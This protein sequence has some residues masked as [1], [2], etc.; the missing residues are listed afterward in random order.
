MINLAV[1]LLKNSTKQWLT[2]KKGSKFI[3][4]A[5]LLI[6]ALF[7]LLQ[8]NVLSKPEEATAQLVGWVVLVILFVFILFGLLSNR[9]PSRMEDVMWI[10][11]LPMSMSRIVWTC[12]C[13]QLL[14]RS[15]FWLGSALIADTIRFLLGHTYEHLFFQAFMS[16][17]VISLLEVGLFAASSSRGKWGVSI[18]VGMVGAIGL[19]LTAFSFFVTQMEKSLFPSITAAM[20]L[21]AFYVGA[22][23]MGKFHLEGFL[24]VV[25]FIVLAIVVIQAAAKGLELKEK[26]TREA[27]F[28]SSFS[29]FSSLAAA[30]KGGD[31]A[32]Y[33]GGKAWTGV[34]SFVWFEWVLWRKH[35]SALV[36]QFI[37]GAGLA[38][39]MAIKWPS[40]LMIYFGII[41]ASALIGGFFS[42]L[43]RHAQ[44]GDLLLLPG[45]RLKKIVLLEIVDLIPPFAT[46]WLY[47]SISIAI[48]ANLSLKPIA[49]IGWLLVLIV[50]IACFR[51]SLFVDVFL[52]NLDISMGSYYKRLF[53]YSIAIAGIIFILLFL[54]STLIE[55]SIG[56]LVAAVMATV[57]LYGVI[58][59]YTYK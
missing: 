10:Y 47:Y 7:T 17:A 29:S 28:W 12:L 22:F 51:I 35:R 39:V 32:S 57:I 18:A 4:I 13:W 46:V 43:I 6:L 9:L 30:A 27:D 40:W 16:L 37:A 52:K 5:P 25:V 11:M 36:F 21:L 56:M 26:L 1:F 59:I 55:L 49:F 14:L 31:Q 3:I 41:L 2:N 38:I 53:I 50:A 48:G 24:F 23:M 33:W 44:S 34:F 54:D 45:S 58:R 42:G 19:V 8:M 15:S 20:E